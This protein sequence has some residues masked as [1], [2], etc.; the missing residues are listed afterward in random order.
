MNNS[1][2]W[3]FLDLLFHSLKKATL[4]VLF[5]SFSFSWAQKEI[6]PEYKDVLDRILK[7]LHYEKQDNLDSLNSILKNSGNVCMETLAI[8]YEASGLYL[9][10]NQ[11]EKAE[12]KSLE[13]IDAGKFNKDKMHPTCYESTMRI[14]VIRLFYIYRRKG[15]FDKAINIISQSKEFFKNYELQSFV[16]TNHLDMGH[17]KKA[18]DLFQNSLK[19][20]S[21]HHRTFDFTYNQSVRYSRTASI[22]QSIADAYVQLFQ[23]SD[24]PS[25]LDSASVHY[26]KSYADG[27]M[28][29]RN[30]AY[31]ASLYYLNT[32]KIEHY[33]KNYRKAIQKYLMYFKHPVMKD[34]SF[35]Y[36][37]YCLSLA[38][39]YLQLNDLNSAL[40]NLKKLD[41][42]Y[43][44]NP[45]S[46]QFYIAGL[47]TYMEV[48]QLKGND[49]KALH[50]A[51]LYLDKMKTL[52]KNKVNAIEAMNILNI[53]DSNQKAQDIIESKN[54]WVFALVVTG[55]ILA[56]LIFFIIRKQK[57]NTIKTQSE[58]RKLVD[59][60]EEQMLYKKEEVY[61]KSKFVY[62]EAMMAQLEKK[63]I[64]FEK[65]KD[66][67][68][69]EFKLPYLA[70]KLG[71]NTAYLSAFFNE[72][73]G[74][75]FNHYLQDKRMHYLLELL[76]TNPLYLKYTVQAISEHIGYKSP[77]AF[78]KVFKSYTGLNFS[79]YLDKIKNN[80]LNNNDLSSI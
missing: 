69:P 14:S 38:E 49:K 67:L 4:L 65:S 75:S 79:A 13:C 77:S 28:F 31:N 76:E 7:V 33:K 48:Y 62:D 43:A 42:S 32:G 20:L 47:S 56:V 22:H 39:S 71:T 57:S 40:R 74:K 36:Q 25:L 8:H 70:K 64:E 27:N 59:S 78:S 58:H 68:K 60:L 11:I 19:E 17:Y 5:L 80:E 16:A 45:G 73:L 41:S 55:I 18:I 44:K 37:S 53:E 30:F 10:N 52:D 46:E 9:I 72:K 61:E 51:K 34:N 23:S 1:P 24:E 66:F 63:F 2:L 50:Y 12:A 15:E 35:T 29:N 3:I 54:Y 6:H 26:K 21:V